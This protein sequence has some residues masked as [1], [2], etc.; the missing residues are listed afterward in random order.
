MWNLKNNTNEPIR[1]TEIDLQVQETKLW[2]PK[3]E[4]GVAINQE[5]GKI[6]RLT[7]THYYI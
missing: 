1:K 4:G 6:M 7:D 3:G 5:F 2:L